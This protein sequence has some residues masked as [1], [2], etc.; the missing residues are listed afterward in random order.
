MRGVQPGQDETIIGVTRHKS[1]QKAEKREIPGKI[2][3][4]GSYKFRIDR[5][6][7]LG[8]WVRGNI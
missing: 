5:K 4:Y 7:F 6:N 3:F 2:G 8:E 1:A